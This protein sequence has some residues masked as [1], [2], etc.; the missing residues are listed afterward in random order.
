MTF[1]FDGMLILVCT[2][3]LYIIGYKGQSFYRESGELEDDFETFN[4]YFRK[5]EKDAS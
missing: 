2:G 3:L 5:N 1:C 4:R